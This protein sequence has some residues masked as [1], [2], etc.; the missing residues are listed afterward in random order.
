MIKTLLNIVQLT[1]SNRQGNKSSIPWEKRKIYIYLERRFH[2]TS[3][4]PTNG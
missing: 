3:Y 2:S 4:S 1:T